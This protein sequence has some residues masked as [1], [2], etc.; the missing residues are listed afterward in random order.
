MQ[1]LPNG[2]AQW[3]DANG[4]PLANGTV[5]FYAPGTLN[6]QGTWQDQAG[7]IPN[8][9]PITLDSRGQAIV[10]GTGTYR[11]IVQDASGVTIWDQIVDT[12]AGGAALANTTGAGG[13][14]L[15]GFNNGT[16]A[17]FLKNNSDIIV[18]SIAAVRALD[19]TVFIKAFADGYY[20]AGDG[21]GGFY[22][23][24]SSDTT[25]T[26]NGGT[27]IV[28]SDG[29]R[30][31]LSYTDVL[32]VKQ[33]GAK[34]DGTTDDTGAISNAAAWV[35]SLA[36]QA[37]LIFPKGTYIYSSSPNWGKN[38]ARILAKGEVRLR[39]TGTAA[40]VIID[41]GASSTS[42][43]DVTFGTPEEPFIIEAPATATDACYV[44][45]VHHSHIS[46]KPRGAGPSSAGLRVI[47]CVCSEFDVTCTVNE[48]GGWY[49]S[50]KPA[51][52]IILDQRAVGEQTSYC[53][54]NN[55]ILEGLPTGAQFFGSQGNIVFG[56]TIEGCAV[57]ADFYAGATHNRMIG[58]DFEAN[59]S[60]DIR[61][62]GPSNSNEFINV[63]TALLVYVVAGN[64]NRFTGGLHQSIRID[65]GTN[66][67]HNI[68]YN[69]NG[70]GTFTDNPGTQMRLKTFN[71]AL[72]QMDQNTGSYVPLAASTVTVGASPFLYTNTNPYP[73][74]VL[75]YGGTVSQTT[76]KRGALEIPVVAGS[77]IRL[78]PNDSSQCSYSSIP[79]L[80]VWPRQG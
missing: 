74:D 4:A 64:S 72:G 24:D 26:D 5:G 76:I 61:L 60:V 9:N 22:Y 49:S 75:W 2:K 32:T 6:P 27:V 13:A 8:P 44:R 30:W 68:T 31:K 25:S 41:G 36:V 37:A 63:D 17:S 35:Q 10:W 53:I 20:V 70:S 51:V 28:A 15:I 73:V 52:G 65:G 55:P 48:D 38:H 29:G 7:T 58:T 54:F 39:Y 11:Q 46:V 47:F 34:G 62:Q 40:A 23:Y 59:T 66:F 1:L 50:A 79:S 21:G 14:A 77:L 57:G 67:F 45:A 56:G 3:I 16:L 78:E 71:S 19:H 42:V 43:Y 12:P 69:R 18:D 80:T 33:F